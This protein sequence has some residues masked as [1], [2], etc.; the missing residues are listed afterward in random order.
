LVDVERLPDHQ[1]MVSE[2]G[3]SD[4]V[5][6]LSSRD[7][8]WLSGHLQRVKDHKPADWEKARATIDPTIFRLAKSG[9]IVDLL[10]PE[11]GNDIVLWG[12]N[13][14]LLRPRHRH[15][16]HVDIE[17][18]L[19]DGP[20]ISV[21][22]GLRNCTAKSGL[23]LVAGS[24][25]SGGLLQQCAANEGIKYG[26]A[27]DDTVL[28]WA[29]RFDPSALLFTP[30]VSDGEAIF[31]DGKIWH[32]AKNN[33]FLRRRHALVLQYAPA[34]VAIRIPD[35]GKLDWPFRLKAA[36]M[37][38]T[39]L[40]SGRSQ[41]ARN[42]IVPPPPMKHRDLTSIS[43]NVHQYRLP[44]AEDTEKGWKPYDPFFGQTGSLEL[45][46]YHASVLSPGQ[47][48][49]PP[50]RHPE[51]EFLIILDG[52]AEV[53]IA[54]SPRDQTPTVKR[55]IK[56]QASYYPSQQHHTIR[57]VSA[58]PVTY[59]MLRWRSSQ[60]GT[61]WPLSTQIF[62]FASARPKHPG[63]GLAV[64]VLADEPTGLLSKLHI[65]LSELAPG[66]GY[67]P[68]VDAYDAAILVL[69]GEIEIFD[70]TAGP[71]SM[72]LIA[73]GEPHGIFNSTD[74]PA[75]YLVLELHR[76]SGFNRDMPPWLRKSKRLMSRGFRL[77]RRVVRRLQS[78]FQAGSIP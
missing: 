40:V 14:V 69:D 45:F 23:T 46:G 70:S 74:K 39:I 52:E 33:Y 16:W 58:N 76:N 44:L 54:D 62:D 4:P 68:H 77:L 3:F 30:D 73:A 50:H 28:G 51:E 11:L 63:R 57:N 49:H 60:T 21:W 27:N 56:H 61:K 34:D 53:V 36:P 67:E 18:G 75:K 24:H 1:A 10:R 35:M 55:L 43:T 12:V 31:I 48:P 41:G 2:R 13:R 66:H 47:C 29:R 15:A 32:S 59:L 20:C 8:H 19:A 38:Q 26:L 22:I 7:A 5:R 64:L 9:T 72:I 37:P 17:T 25:R 42:R 65:H 71:N 6:V 78:K